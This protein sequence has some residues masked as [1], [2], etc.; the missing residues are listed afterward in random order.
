ME[1]AWELAAVSEGKESKLIVSAD[2]SGASISIEGQ[3]A[4]DAAL[5]L[6][7]TVGFFTELGGVFKDGLR[8]V[9][10][11]NAIKNIRRA[12]DLT[13]KLNVPV[14]PIAPRFLL[15]WLDGA[16]LSDSENDESLANMWSSLLASEGINCAPENLYFISLLKTMSAEEAKIF[17]EVYSEA[18]KN[19]LTEE[20]LDQY[21]R[22][23]V[24]ELEKKSLKEISDRN[25]P[26]FSKINSRL[27]CQPGTRVK[28]IRVGTDEVS[29]GIGLR[30][31]SSASVLKVKD[32]LVLQ[33]LL[34]RGLIRETVSE[35]ETD[36][37]VF[38]KVSFYTRTLLGQRFFSSVNSEALQ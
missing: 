32:E 5:A 30:Y 16:S 4:D 10:Q 14:K 15:E 24:A 22:P 37:G 35:G 36:H 21:H 25:L 38:Y 34:S 13:K 20:L 31:F 18:E 8:A 9:R 12:E 2:L 11:R 26:K 3:A 27:I 19:L 23:I 29:K 33:A 7:D 6:L 28:F 17:L 1:E